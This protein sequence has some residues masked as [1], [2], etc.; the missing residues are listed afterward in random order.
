MKNGI[1]V[2]PFGSKNRLSTKLFSL[3]QIGF[4]G[5]GNHFPLYLQGFCCGRRAFLGPAF[6]TSGLNTRFQRHV[7]MPP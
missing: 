3:L 2:R 6:C 5:A 1:K 4:A 7:M